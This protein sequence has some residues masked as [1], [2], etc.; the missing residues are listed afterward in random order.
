MT[1]PCLIHRGQLSVGVIHILVYYITILINQFKYSL[2]F[3]RSICLWMIA[4]RSQLWYT[5]DDVIKWK[6]FPRYRPFVREIHRSP[7][8]SPH[9]CQWRGALMFSLICARING[10]VNDREAGD[11]RCHSASF[12]V[13]IMLYTHITYCKFAA[14]IFL[15]D[16]IFWAIS[17]LKRAHITQTN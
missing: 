7:V 14:I 10:W 1:E 2:G 12:D 4:A 13:I 16:C 17:E 8:N 9:K 6:H 5:Y 11:L 3:F 15:K